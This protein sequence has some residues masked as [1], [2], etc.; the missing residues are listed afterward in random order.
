MNRC[1][2]AHERRT[3]AG[4]GTP[5]GAPLTRHL[6]IPEGGT[7]RHHGPMT[8]TPEAPAE[9]EL[10]ANDSLWLNMDSPENLMVIETRHVVPPPT[11]PRRRDPS[12]AGADGRQ[13]PGVPL[14]AALLGRRRAA[15]TSGSTTRTSTSTG[16]SPS[17]SWAATGG[18]AEL[19]AVPRGPV[20]RA[21]RPGAPAVA[22][23]RPRGQRLRRGD[24][25]LPPRD[26]RR[27]GAGPGPD[28]DDDRHPRGG[29]R[30][31]GRPRGPAA[32]GRR[33]AGSPRSPPATAI[34]RRK[35]VKALNAVTQVATL[36][37]AAGVK[38]TT[39]AAKL[40]EMLDLDRDGQPGGQ[41][42]RPDGRDGRHPRQARWS[43][44][45]PDV[46]MFGKAG[47]AKRADWAPAHDLAG[48]QAR[49][50]DPRGARSTT[51]CSPAWPA[52]CAATWR[53]AASRSRTS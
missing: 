41:G 51:S 13:V 19:Q 15:A 53:A 39:G 36:P 10:S 26:R 33:A 11:R 2:C 50:A 38:A 7:A 43:G 45:P 1:Q 6:P 32:P 42:R 4:H 3:D 9:M 30:L 47:V 44:T 17:T 35:R 24:D 40:L 12:P 20:R 37:L 25:P 16:T 22:R 27:H 48:G 52:A 18:R 23:L 31:P 46:A 34:A 28:R 5:G 21:D 8:T 29:L 14:E 49:G